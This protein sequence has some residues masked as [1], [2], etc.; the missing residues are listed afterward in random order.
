MKIY[1]RCSF[2]FFILVLG[3][4]PNNCTCADLSFCV[5]I[6]CVSVWILK[7]MHPLLNTEISIAQNQKKRS[8]IWKLHDNMQNLY[9]TLTKYIGNLKAHIGHN[10][11]LKYDAITN[12]RIG[13]RRHGTT[14][15]HLRITWPWWNLQDQ[16]HTT[17]GNN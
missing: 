17:I 15:I 6:I 11:L 10:V 3:I 12:L 7:Y 13:S 4:V 14:T 2:L 16:G 8:H 5:K 1:N 9:N